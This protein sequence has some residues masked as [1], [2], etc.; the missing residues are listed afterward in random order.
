[1][2]N[3]ILGI[4]IGIILSLAVFIPI[5]QQTIESYR[6]VGINNGR[7][8][9]LWEIAEIIEQEFGVYD[10]NLEYR[11]LFSIK[12]TDIVIV[13]KSSEKSIRVIR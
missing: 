2:K 8:T 9:A 11:R 6:T 13:N 3:M 5:R 10:D 4:F 12:T 7:I 1:M